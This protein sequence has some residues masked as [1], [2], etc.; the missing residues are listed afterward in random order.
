MII[1]DDERFAI[2]L[3]VHPVFNV[4]FI[5]KWQAGASSSCKP[6]VMQAELNGFMAAVRALVKPDV[7]HA[8]YRTVDTGNKIADVKLRIRELC[9]KHSIGR[10]ALILLDK[11]D[12]VQSVFLRWEKSLGWADNDDV[13][14]TTCDEAI[15]EI[16]AERRIY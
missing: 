3:L 14:W 13:Y 16:L 10:N 5:E 15:K 2:T 12:F 7:Q 11:E 9:M 6:P 4:D 1:T 8:I